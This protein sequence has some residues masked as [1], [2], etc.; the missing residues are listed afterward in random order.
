MV[1]NWIFVVQVG[2]VWFGIC[3]DFFSGAHSHPKNQSCL[4]KKQKAARDSATCNQH[5]NTSSN[6]KFGSVFARAIVHTWM[7]WCI[8][9][10]MRAQRGVHLWMHANADVLVMVVFLFV[11]ALLTCYLRFRQH[12]P[13][14]N[15][16]TPVYA[17]AN[18]AP[19]PAHMHMHVLTTLQ[20]HYVNTV[21]VLCMSSLPSIATL[22]GET[23]SR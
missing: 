12:G 16:S 4:Q 11:F 23:P 5:A 19:M 14:T 17:H 3:S 9:A 7:H 10:L 22:C 8:D 15:C 20:R 2:V 13:A 21:N 1:S 6:T 18:A